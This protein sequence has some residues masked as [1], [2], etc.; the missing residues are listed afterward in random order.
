MKINKLILEKVLNVDGFNS[1][2]TEIESIFDTIEL[3]LK[4]ENDKKI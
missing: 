3:I 2:K 1:K 4:K